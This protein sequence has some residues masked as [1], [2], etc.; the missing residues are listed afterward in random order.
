MAGRGF[1]KAE[2]ELERG[3][4]EKALTELHS[5]WSRPV[6]RDEARLAEFQRLVTVIQQKSDGET[7]EKAG[8]FLQNINRHIRGEV[9]DHGGTPG[10]AQA[11]GA[12]EFVAEGFDG[13]LRVSRSRLVI[14]PKGGMKTLVSGGKLLRGTKEIP[15]AEVTAVQFRTTPGLGFNGNIQISYKG[16]MDLPGLPSENTVYF[17][18]SATGIRE[19]ERAH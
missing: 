8:Q 5:E 18:T 6:E 1:Q 13:Y 10:A 17:E 9:P 3:N 7:R 11:S 4:P 16:G 15:L 14:E 19:G 12:S 2:R